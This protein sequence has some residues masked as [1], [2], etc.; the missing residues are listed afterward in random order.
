MHG[1]LSKFEIRSSKQIPNP[2]LEKL[3]VPL[4]SLRLVGEQGTAEDAEQRR[5]DSNFPFVSEVSDFLLRQLIISA[6]RPS[7]ESR[8][9]TDRLAA[10]SLRFRVS[11]VHSWW[12]SG[13]AKPQ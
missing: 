8:S 10:G 4:R 2:K 9:P 1:L 5:E 6:G 13:S 3:R 7:P 12:Q 11:T